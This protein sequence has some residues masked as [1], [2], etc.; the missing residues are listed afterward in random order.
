M[1]LLAMWRDEHGRGGKEVVESGLPVL[2]EL[3]ESLV[4]EWV[5]DEF[6]EYVDGDG[7]DTAAKVR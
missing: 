2:H 1:R 7:K 6:G 3:V 5:F 4:C